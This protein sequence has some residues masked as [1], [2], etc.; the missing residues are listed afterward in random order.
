M[1]KTLNLD[2][3]A[4]R[5]SQN[6]VS[7]CN[8]KIKIL[9]RVVTKTLGVL[10][11]QGVYAMILFLFSRSSEEKD[12]AGFIRKQLYQVLSSIREVVPEF[13]KNQV[14]PDEKTAINNVL[15]FYSS[16]EVMGDTN[17]LFLIRDLYEQ[18]LIYTRYGAKA[19][20]KGE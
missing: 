6:M 16:D 15:A 18:T 10:Q 2:K 1:E 7:D 13:L 11:E 12:V 9:E 3:L 19:L 20:S 5:Y 4:A 17:T 8:D 14:M